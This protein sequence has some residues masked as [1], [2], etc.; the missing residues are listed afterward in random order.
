MSDHEC[1]AGIERHSDGQGHIS[2]GCPDLGLMGY[3]SIEELLFQI[4]FKLK[5]AGT[6]NS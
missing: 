3:V 2:Y 1:I 4:Y 6:G 5:T